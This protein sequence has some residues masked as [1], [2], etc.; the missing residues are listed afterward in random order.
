MSTLSKDV[1][2]KI[3]STNRMLGGFKARDTRR[4]NELRRKALAWFTK[5]AR[6]NNWYEPCILKHLQDDWGHGDCTVELC[7]DWGEGEHVSRW[8]R[9]WGEATD[10]LIEI[11]PK[12]C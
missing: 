12:C 7:L 11:A 2:Y 10:Y 6:A 9:S 5:L 4:L 3:K 1:P 8:F